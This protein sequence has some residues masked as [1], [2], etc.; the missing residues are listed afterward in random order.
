MVE[1]SDEDLLNI[2]NDARGKSLKNSCKRDKV[3]KCEVLEKKR[4]S[5]HPGIEELDNFLNGK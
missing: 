1:L 2:I 3:F 4:L 5:N